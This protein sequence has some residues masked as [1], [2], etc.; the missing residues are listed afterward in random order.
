MAIDPVTM[1]K[2]SLNHLNLLKKEI[3]KDFGQIEI[4]NITTIGFAVEEIIEIVKEQKIDLVVMG[5]KGAS[6]VTEIL[7]GS[8]TSDVFEKCH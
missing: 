4:E 7:I 2:D 6:G 8:N 5:T 1:E 3:E